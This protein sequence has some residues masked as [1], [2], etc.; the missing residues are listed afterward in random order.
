MNK[1]LFSPQTIEQ[2]S[3]IL[4]EETTNSKI[5]IMLRTLRLKDI[6]TDGI[7]PSKWARIND[8]IVTNQNETQS[9]RSLID[10]TEWIMNP[11]L[12]MSDPDKRKIY[13][14][15]LKNLNDIFCYTGLWVNDS[16]KIAST[17]K[18]S[19]HQEALNRCSS[20]KKSLS[21]LDIHPRVI[22]TCRPELLAENYFHLVFES[23]K[24]VLSKIREITDLTLDGNQL[25]DAAFDG[26][27][28]RVIMNTLQT[29]DE[30]SDHKGLKALLQFITCFYRNPK[31]H[32]LKVYSPDKEA[33][34]ITAL[35]TISLALKLLDKCSRNSARQ[36]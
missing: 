5:S 32:N 12:F 25:I 18:I 10:I 19:S 24:L 16:G 17:S 21:I 11:V 4:G 29:Q 26:N 28:P 22:S 9:G 34:A 20:L 2:I 33:D 14:V 23:A 31:A 30:K 35:A 3:R 36:N 15:I 6:A 27:N 7:K 8:A 1:L 13:T